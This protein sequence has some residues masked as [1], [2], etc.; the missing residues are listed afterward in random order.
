[1]HAHCVGNTVRDWL[2]AFGDAELQSARSAAGIV[3]HGRSAA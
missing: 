1:M 3:Q 2:R